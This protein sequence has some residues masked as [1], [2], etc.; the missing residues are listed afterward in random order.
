M[1]R[2]VLGL[3][4]GAVLGLFDGLSA[5]FYPEARSMMLPIVLAS[6]VKGVLTGLAVGFV[7]R[8]RQ[9]VPLGVFSGIV[10]GFLLSTVA[11][12]GQPEQ[13]WTI[14]LPG[15]LVGAITGVVCHRARP[16]LAALGLLLILSSAAAAE[17]S[18]PPSPLGPVQALIGKWQGTSEG[19]P[20][21]GTLTREYRM[22]LGDRFVEEI[23]RS[24]YLPQQKNPKGETHEHR[25][26]FSYD[27]ARKQIVFRQFHQEGFVNQ[28][29]LE[30]STKAGVLVFVTEAIENIPNGF[31]ARETYTFMSANE[32]EEVFEI[33][34][35]GKD[36]ELY[37]RARLK[38]AP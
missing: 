26:I 29:V 2:P 32:F 37:S 20:G 7:A 35:P 22:I 24:V 11:A 19:Q 36:F 12:M 27:R 5:W 9:S 17:Q 23:N 1:T 38:R 16:A 34:E 33:A 25:S 6:T 3:V 31:R 28:Y 13:Y 18:T 4:T 14:V 15:M 21:S 30:P 8:R 10:V